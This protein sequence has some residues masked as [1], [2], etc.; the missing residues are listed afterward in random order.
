M[1]ETNLKMLSVKWWPFC[2]GLNVL[3]A[4]ICKSCD[5]KVQIPLTHTISIS[6]LENI[7]ISEQFWLIIFDDFRILF[8]SVFM[9]FLGFFFYLISNKCTSYIV[10]GMVNVYPATLSSFNPPPIPTVVQPLS[11]PGPF[12]EDITPSEA[13]ARLT[14]H[15]WNQIWG[16]SHRIN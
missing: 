6:S 12:Q 9:V 2:L 1:K 11:Y 14:S 4:P 16:N 13:A 15:M 3:S 7:C 10:T 5:G 8:Q